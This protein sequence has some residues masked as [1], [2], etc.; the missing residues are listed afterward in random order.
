MTQNFPFNGIPFFKT[1]PAA[2]LISGAVKD[3]KTPAG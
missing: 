3:K 2:A 1:S